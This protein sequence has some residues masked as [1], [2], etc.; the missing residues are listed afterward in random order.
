[1]SAS[2]CRDSAGSDGGD[3]QGGVCNVSPM[4]GRFL[5]IEVA[6]QREQQAAAS[7]EAALA[8]NRRRNGA[9]LQGRPRSANTSIQSAN[10]LRDW[11]IFFLPWWSIPP[12]TISGHSRG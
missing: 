1:M 6:V 11:S 8:I 10:L 2:F 9:D 5:N 3:L 12:L 7:S 4:Q